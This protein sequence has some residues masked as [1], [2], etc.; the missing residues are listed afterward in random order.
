MS[1]PGPGN[2]PGDLL[3]S[4]YHSFSPEGHGKVLNLWAVKPRTVRVG[5][6]P[7]CL[8]AG[9]FSKPPASVL[10]HT[11]PDQ[12]HE[13]SLTPPAGLE[14]A[15]PMGAGRLSRALRYHFSMAAYIIKRT[16]ILRSGPGWTRTNGVSLW[17]FYRPLPSPLGILT[18]IVLEQTVRVGFEPTCLPAEQFSR[19]SAYVRLP[20][21]PDAW[22]LHANT[23][24]GARTP[25]SSL[26]GW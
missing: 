15:Q 1:I 6:G 21:A 22:T 10:L 26:K 16:T 23:A 13:R 4:T 25:V 17:G 9:R 8:P 11:A 7:T 2:W 14:P 24:S 5:F 19:L 18:L 20:T 3:L 12:P